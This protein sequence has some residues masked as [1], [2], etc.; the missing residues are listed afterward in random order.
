MGCILMLGAC[1]CCRRPFCFNPHRVPSERVNG[2]RQP[3]CRNCVEEANPIRKAKGLE[4]IKIYE[5]SYEPI[6]EEEL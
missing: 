4:P 3:I 5:D 2:V 1:V 6:A